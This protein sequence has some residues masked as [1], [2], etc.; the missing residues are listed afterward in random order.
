MS[1]IA[2]FHYISACL[3]RDPQAKRALEVSCQIDT[4]SAG[5]KGHWKATTFVTSAAGVHDRLYADAVAKEKMRE[6]SPARAERLVFQGDLQLQRKGEI[7]RV[8]AEVQYGG[9]GY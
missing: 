7:R 6:A 4:D 8:D 3:G 9:L 5:R 1:C 2:Q